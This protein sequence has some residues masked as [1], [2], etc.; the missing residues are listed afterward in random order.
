MIIDNAGPLL[1]GVVSKLPELYRGGKSDSLIEFSRPARNEFL[2]LVES[3]LVPL[4]FMSDV[5]QSALTLVSGYYLSA[6]T[7]LIDV[8]GLE[9][10][11]TLDQ[12]NTKRDPIESMLGTGASIYKFVGTES[13]QHGLPAPEDS[14]FG[15]EA[16]G[17]DETTILDDNGNANS[18]RLGREIQT[19]IKELSNLSVGKQFEVIFARDGNEQPVQLQ[20]RLMVTDTDTKSMLT[21]LSMGSIKN[22]FKER[23][24]RAKAGE[25]TYIKDLVLCQD[26]IDEARATRIRDKSGFFEHIMRKRSG[27]FL[28]GLFTLRPSINNAS[29]V[30]IISKETA[31][32]LELELGGKLSQFAVR[33]QV[34]KSTYAMLLI[35]IDEWEV[36]TFYHRS[37][38]T[39]TEMRASEL[40]RANKSSGTDVEDILRAYSSFSAPTL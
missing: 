22:T 18:A 9:V 4:P 37:I 31:K 34:F 30:I 26:L 29:A 1:T 33:E 39:P 6:L 12:I 38:D 15:F 28:S 20:I 11:K 10:V 2:T 32:Q 25:L 40:K 17:D 14:L 5:V 19:S 3:K 7:L 16:A 36:V 24:F 13:Y 8:P 35:V 23:F 21:I 27:N